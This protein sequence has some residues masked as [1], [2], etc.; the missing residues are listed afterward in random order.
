MVDEISNRDTGKL[1]GVAKRQ[2]LVPV[3]RRGE[4]PPDAGLRQ[5][6]IVIEMHEQGLRFV[7]IE[8]HDRILARRAKRHGRVVLQF[9]NAES[10]HQAYIMQELL[11]G[12]SCRNKQAS[13]RLVSSMDEADQYAEHSELQREIDGFHPDERPRARYFL[14]GDEGQHM[15]GP[16]EGAGERGELESPAKAASAAPHHRKERR[17]DDALENDREQAEQEVRLPLEIAVR[18]I[19]FLEQKHVPDHGEHERADRVTKGTE[20]QF[21]RFHRHSLKLR[22]RVYWGRA[23]TS[24]CSRSNPVTR[25]QLSELERAEHQPDPFILRPSCS[26]ERW[27]LFLSAHFE[28]F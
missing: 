8:H 3:Q 5:Q 13:G 22:A 28:R 23:F 12:T 6:R 24:P 27:G 26:D 4:R 25:L 17:E 11:A 9:S 14:L 1:R 15:R 2:A 7:A 16:E 21:L 18:S 19:A 20:N 10:F